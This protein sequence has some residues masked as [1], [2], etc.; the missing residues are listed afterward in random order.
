MDWTARKAKREAKARL[1]D[2]RRINDA[3]FAYSPSTC[4]VGIRWNE[5]EI[6]RVFN[7]HYPMYRKSELVVDWVSVGKGLVTEEP[8]TLD[9][10]HADMPVFRAAVRQLY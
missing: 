3:E 4:A 5:S 1:R 8:Y 10:L 7:V 6:F 9:K 2:N